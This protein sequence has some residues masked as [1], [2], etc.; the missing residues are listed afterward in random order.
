MPGDRR[1][2]GVFSNCA[3]RRG[4]DHESEIPDLHAKI[5]E[6]IVER[7]FVSRGSG[8]SGGRWWRAIT[9]R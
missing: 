5:G 1:L 3:E 2:G 8:R 4:R 9:R 6:L 7:D